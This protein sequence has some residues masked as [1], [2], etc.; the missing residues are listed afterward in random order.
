MEL[1]SATLSKLD[2]SV[3]SNL[4]LQA[5]C[6]QDQCAAIVNRCPAEIRVKPG[7][8]DR[9]GTADLNAARARNVA[10]KRT[11]CCLIELDDTA[12]V[13]VAL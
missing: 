1:A 7:K 2:G 10:R 11:C 12:V 5:G 13:D 9:C 4:A 3:I 8:R 6:V